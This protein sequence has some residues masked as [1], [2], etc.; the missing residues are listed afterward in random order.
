MDQCLTSWFDLIDLIF[1]NLDISCLLYVILDGWLTLRL[2][3][4]KMLCFHF[5]SHSVLVR[6]L[7]VWWWTEYKWDE[8]Q[9]GLILIC[10]RISVLWPC[11]GH[12]M[13]S[14][15]FCFH[16]T[17]TLLP[18]VTAEPV[19]MAKKCFYVS[20]PQ[21]LVCGWEAM[22]MNCGLREF[23]TDQGACSSMS[24]AL[25]SLP[26]VFMRRR[27]VFLTTN[28]S[29]YLPD[30]L[31][32]A[33]MLVFHIVSQLSE[34]VVEE[35]QQT[36]FLIWPRKMSSWLVQL[37]ESG[38][39]KRPW[40]ELVHSYQSQHVMLRLTPCDVLFCRNTDLFSPPSFSSCG[41]SSTLLCC[42]K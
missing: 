22:V 6:G 15:A 35:R 23:W 19:N 12:I 11:Q 2:Q 41:C 27:F 36:W 39:H 34:T 5:T 32:S 24:A 33:V 7:T 26:S 9:T 4:L 8:E 29:T 37:C 18:A 30:V 17:S 40:E 14:R 1:A 10:M 38:L 31:L 20:V 28:T 42:I 25:W 13:G 21:E 3:Q 16:H